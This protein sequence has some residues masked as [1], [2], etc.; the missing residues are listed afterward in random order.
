MSETASTNRPLSSV[1]RA[2]NV[3]TYLARV[4]NDG[5]PLKTLA[6]HLNLNKATA[7]HTLSTLRSCGWVEQDSNSGHY[8]LGDGILPLANYRTTTS[9]LVNRVKPLIETLSRQFNELVHLGR[10]NQR[11]IVYLEKVEP[12]QPIRV[13][14]QVGRQ[15]PAAVT[16]L[17]RA[18]LGASINFS[19]R[20]EEIEWMLGRLNLETKAQLQQ[21]R[22]SLRN[23]FT[24]FDST[25]WVCEVEENEAG[26]SCVAAPLPLENNTMLAISVTAPAE[27]MSAE[28]RTEI[29]TALVEEIK[30]FLRN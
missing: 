18:I 26:I 7:H 30:K 22:K 6:Q 28:R 12:D 1:E 24:H 19:E 29:G 5:V 16:A 23:A 15:T 4:E 2:L 27:R 8:R 10:L 11:D 14:S 20:D 9:R 25:G 3:L 17:G 13:H 21:A